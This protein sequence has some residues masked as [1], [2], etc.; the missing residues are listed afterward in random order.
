M[1]AVLLRAAALAAI[2]FALLHFPLAQPAYASA[3]TQQCAADERN[4]FIDCNGAPR[5][6]PTCISDYNCCMATCAG[7]ACP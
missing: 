2:A 6:N 4:C 3:C 5:C 1:K 7:N